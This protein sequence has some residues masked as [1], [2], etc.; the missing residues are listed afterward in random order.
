MLNLLHWIAIFFLLASAAG[1][2]YLCIAVWRVLTFRQ[3][4]APNGKFTPPVTILK[5]IHG[6]EP[7][8]Y[9]NLAS[10]CDQEYAD[11]QIVFGVH[12]AND[13]AL[14]TIENVIASFPERDIALVIGDAST[15]GNPKIANLQRML[16]AVKYD[17]LVIADADMRVEPRYLRAVVA[18][19][20]QSSVGA[21]TALYA[22]VPSGGPYSALAAMFINEQFTPSVLVALT[23]EQLRYCFGS[24]MA[25]RRS[26]LDAI[27]GLDALAPYLADDYMLGKFISEHGLTVALAQTLIHNVVDEPTFAGLWSHQMR[28]ARTIRASRP[29]GYAGSFLTF[30][31]SMTLLYLATSGNIALGVP[32][33]LVAAA[34]CVALHYAARASFAS[35][36][37][38][39]PW[40]APARDLLGCALWAV[41][42]FGRSV[43]WRDA[44]FA[45][46]VA[47]HVTDESAQTG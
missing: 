38:A 3:L 42:Y 11:F 32:L 37:P 31:F 35:E 2:A 19:F 4:P 29:F 41:S 17:L 15:S 20:A 22:G 14:G 23:F 7:E 26:A 8:L 10:F 46:D 9:E 25:V 43:R 1:I 16:G 40:L 18:P 47:G 36:H 6:I 44:K 39:T 5:P 28:W 13:P 24:T 45:V 33:G 27:G 30:G 34:L 21:V 12:D